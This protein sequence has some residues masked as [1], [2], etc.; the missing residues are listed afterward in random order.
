MIWRKRPGKPQAEPP[1][2]GLFS[3]F[4]GTCPVCGAP[5]GPVEVETD[6]LRD[7]RFVVAPPMRLEVGTPDYE[8]GTYMTRQGDR[9][10]FRVTILPGNY[11]PAKSRDPR[12]SPRDVDY[13][14]LLCG[15]GHIFPDPRPVAGEAEDQAVEDWNVFAAVGA[16]AVGKTYLLVRMLGQSL[17]SFDDWSVA[18]DGGMPVWRCEQSRLEAAPLQS[19]QQMYERTRMTGEVIDATEIGGMATPSQI[20]EE[21]Y[22]EALEE[23]KNLVEKT[24]VESRDRSERWGKQFRQPL[25]VRTEIGGTR[26]WTGIVDLPGEVFDSSKVANTRELRT[27]RGFNGLLWV[28]DPVLASNAPAWLSVSGRSQQEVLTAS[29]RPDSV[30]RD[31]IQVVRAHRARIQSD[32]GD[33]LTRPGNPLASPVGPSLN[34]LLAITKCD[35]IHAML[36]SGQQSLAGLGRPGVVVRGGASYLGRMTALWSTEHVT[37]DEASRDLMEYLFAAGSEA[38]KQRCEQVSAELLRHYSEPKRFW[39]LIHGGAEDT[40]FVEKTSDSRT[41]K[42]LNL[43]VPSLAGHLRAALTPE[44][45]E[46]LLFRDLIMSAVGCGI[47]F[48]VGQDSALRKILLAE[49]MR[50]RVFLCSPLGTVPLPKDGSLIEPNTH[51]EPFPEEGEPS[52]ALTQLMLAV[53]EGARIHGAN[54][55]SATS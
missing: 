54:G 50:P 33:R 29:L 30:A 23:I 52:A 28:I 35:L 49:W 24:A 7:N 5:F 16:P 12:F 6:P 44:S 38:R 53:L 20:L 43:R 40:I 13:S 2:D 3:R 45:V 26:V 34:M 42:R 36:A 22:P 1:S 15:G 4:A 21:I 25:T 17:D 55:S 46:D 11:P 48:G 32:I 10:S 18:S 31:S 51:N 41:L 27:L 14:Y 37:V 8:V 39:N 47:G 9:Y 19:R